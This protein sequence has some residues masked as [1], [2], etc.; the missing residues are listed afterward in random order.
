MPSPITV[1][2]QDIPGVIALTLFEDYIY[3][4]D[5]KTKSLSR[6]H[7][8][9]GADRLSLINSWHAIT[10]I[11]VYHS[12][13]QPDGNYSFHDFHNAS[14]SFSRISYFYYFKFRY[15]F[16]IDKND[17]IPLFSFNLYDDASSYQALLLQSM[18]R[19]SIIV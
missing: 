8:T 1:P 3:W 9:S 7:K 10:D 5:G 17:R 4:T 2:N 19:S 18:I 14:T 11:Q 12:Y 16:I 6:V 13:R 15:D